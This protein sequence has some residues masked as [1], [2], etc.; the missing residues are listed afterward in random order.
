MRPL[1]YLINVALE[2]CCDHREISRATSWIAMG[3]A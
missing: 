2:G 3:H 1:R